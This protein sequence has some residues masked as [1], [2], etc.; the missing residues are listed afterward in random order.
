MSENL[1][2]RLQNV[3]TKVHDHE[4]T[5]KN[6]NN[7]INCRIER[8]KAKAKK[9]SLKSKKQ[10]TA[11]LDIYLDSVQFRS[12]TRVNGKKFKFTKL[13]EIYRKCTFVMHATT[14]SSS[15]KPEKLKLIIW[16]VAYIYVQ[17]NYRSGSRR[18]LKRCWMCL[19][20]CQ[21]LPISI[22]P[23]RYVFRCNLFLS[24]KF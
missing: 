7:L 18:W 5:C 8:P 15:E 20:D 17:N 1:K 12:R 11:I 22:T 21:L 23:K 9:C 10:V 24:F 13:S 3:S 4:E 19:F 6:S 16:R 14:E 2:W